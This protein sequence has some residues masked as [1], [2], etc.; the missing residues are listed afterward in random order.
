MPKEYQPFSSK[1]VFIIIGLVVFG[2]M[3]LTSVI[4]GEYYAGKGQLLEYRLF[5][6]GSAFIYYV[7]GYF[8]IRKARVRD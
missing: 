6:L 1:K 7:I 8:L 2:G 4:D 5:I 3:F